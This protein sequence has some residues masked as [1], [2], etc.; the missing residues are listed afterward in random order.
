MLRVRNISNNKEVVVKVTDRG[1]FRR[2]RIIDLSYRAAKI[3][4]MLSQGVVMVEVEPV[5][6]RPPYR[7]EELEIG[8]PQIELD[9]TDVVQMPILDFTHKRDAITQQPVPKL[10]KAKK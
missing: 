2:G 1:P 5:K 4:G 3:L 8:I 6:K 10:P 9:S 7:L